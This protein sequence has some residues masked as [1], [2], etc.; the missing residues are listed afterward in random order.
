MFTAIKLTFLIGVSL[1]LS[2]CKPKS[3]AAKIQ[4][5]NLITKEEAA[6]ALGGPVEVQA[7]PEENACAYSLVGT[8]STKQTH[9]GS[10]IVLVVTADS[11]RF[12]KFGV[13]E[14]ARTQTKPVAGVGDRAVLFMSRDH[15][16][17]SPKALQVMKGNMYVA[18]AI[19]TSNP[20]VSEDAL[21]TLAAKALTR[22]P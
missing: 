13:T 22:L 5:C 20:P 10:L 11:P 18:V 16:D 8:G 19:S 3:S 15:P 7:K 17:I 2:G 4:P 14:D 21:K 12:Q 1:Y 9:F 6:A